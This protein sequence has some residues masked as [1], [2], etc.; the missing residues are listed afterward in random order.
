MEPA[1]LGATKNARPSAERLPRPVARPHRPPR[2][3]AFDPGPREAT[4]RLGGRAASRCG[5]CGVGF[6]PR[7]ALPCCSKELSVRELRALVAPVAELLR[8]LKGARQMAADATQPG[9]PPK[10]EGD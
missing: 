6:L 10:A 4:S 5:G 2:G 9:I 7:L 1:V 3:L 8:G